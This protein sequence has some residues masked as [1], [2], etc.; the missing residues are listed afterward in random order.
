MRQRAAGARR[1]TAHRMLMIDV[2]AVV[3]AAVL[4]AVA[5]L[6]LYWARGGRWPGTDAASLNA[7]V[8]G[9]RAGAPVPSTAATV[10]VAIA[11]T[12]VAVGVLAARGLV[13]V[14]APAAVRV[15][16]WIAA[17]VLAARGLGGF[18]DR[19]LRPH[20]RAL[21]FARWNTWL[22]SPLCVAL[23]LGLIVAL[24]R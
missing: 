7:L 1:G 20:T 14:P 12:G 3:T 11:V 2:V 18:F 22:Y 6:H 15:L 5:A 8:V 17:A 24:A 4:L 19:W 23:A 10:G 21:P 9:G 16:T 13:P